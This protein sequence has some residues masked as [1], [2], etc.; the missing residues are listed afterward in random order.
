M[1]TVRKK[2]TY[3]SCTNTTNMKNHCTRFH[4]DE[5]ILDVRIGLE[6][7]SAPV[8]SLRNRRI[9]YNVLKIVYICCVGTLWLIICRQEAS[10]MVTIHCPY[11]SRIKVRVGQGM[12]KVILPS[13]K[14]VFIFEI[15][16]FINYG[17]LTATCG[18]R[19]HAVPYQY[20][21]MINNLERG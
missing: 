12:C 7:R 3:V 4:K 2:K 10:G 18:W 15:Y 1:Q 20:L 11:F 13:L 17:C 5:W 9:S 21:R 19:N 14:C 8:A 6:V 16:H